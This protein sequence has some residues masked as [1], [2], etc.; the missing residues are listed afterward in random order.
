MVPP[1]SLSSP[2]RKIVDGEK[3]EERASELRQ[4]LDREAVYTDETRR[5]INR[6]LF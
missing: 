1:F 4:T 2:R 6:R 5:G 3:Q